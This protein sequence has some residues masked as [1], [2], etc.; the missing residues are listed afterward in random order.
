MLIAAIVLTV[1][2]IVLLI[3]G[4]V[5]AGKAALIA[6]TETVKAAVIEAD[7]R[8]VAAEI[9]AGSFAK[10]LEVKGTTACA[11]PLVAEFSGTSCVRYETTVVREYEESYVE[12]DSDGKSRTGTRRG[13]E[14]VSS[15]SRSCPF[16]V[17]DGSGRI[18]V[19]PTGAEFH[20]ETT[21]SRF[22]PGEGERTVGSYVLRAIISGAG[23]R[24]TIGYRFTEKCFPVGRQA[25]VLGEATDA[26]GALRIRK[27]EER[28]RRFIVSLKSEEELVRSARLGA[29]WLTISAGISIAGAIAFVVLDLLRK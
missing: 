18:E 17:E 5:M 8:S 15:S 22:E 2:A 4:R 21:V 20:L 13:S 12:T 6:G 3:I 7:C 9:G 1:S 11:S 25:Y 29:L 19:D 27:S 23:G 10:Y 28:G 26:G 16:F 14:T 24:R